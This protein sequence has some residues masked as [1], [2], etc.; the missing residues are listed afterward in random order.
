MKKLTQKSKLLIGYAISGLGDQFYTFA[1]PLLTLSRTH[2]S[3]I[4][5]LLTAVEYLPT[6]L[7]GLTIGP[8]FDMYSRKKIM[9]FSL[10][11]QMV[12]IIIAP[13]LVI[14]NV[15]IYWLLLVVFLLGSFDLITWTGYQIFIAESVKKEE[16]SSVSGQVGLISSVQKTFG[17]GIA[18]VII[19]LINYIGGFLLD[20]L[21]FGYL[22]YVIKD[23]EPLI[24]ENGAM[25]KESSFNNSAKKG[26]SFLFAHHN[27][28]WLI[29]S[30]FVANVGFQAVVPM[31]TFLLKQKMQVSVNLVSIFFTVAAVASI[32]GNSVYLKI[33][34]N[35]KLGTQMLMI[36]SLIMI[37]F[38]IMLNVQSYLLVTF[39]YAL[40]SFGSV[41]SQANFF[42]V[43]QAE[44][45]DRYKGTITSISTSLT[46]I[47]GPIMSLISGFLI[48][49]E[50]HA[51]FIV[52][53]ICMFGSILITVFSG[54]SKL[55]KLE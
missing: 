52:A 3:I 40:V 43:I 24:T 55:G 39:G 44:T 30:F 16:L 11:M 19:N 53:A 10:I 22:T 12:L 38:M 41:W 4:M 1:I 47:I 20:A 5:G 36:A 49:A 26:I 9:L 8:I 42:T 18:A 33:N 17:P 32:I 6:A 34:K 45:P 48:K 31:L 51:I 54:L 37:G 2:S 29:A 15:S 50:V 28:K 46:R 23:Y 27:I 25:K 14:K 7:F 13:F 35:L 21:S